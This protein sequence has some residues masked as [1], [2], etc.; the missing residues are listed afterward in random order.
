MKHCVPTQI[1][2]DRQASPTRSLATPNFDLDPHS[3]DSRNQYSVNNV[4]WS[5]SDSD[6]PGKR[7]KV[8][9]VTAWLQQQNMLAAPV[10]TPDVQVHGSW[11]ESNDRINQMEEQHRQERHAEFGFESN[12]DSQRNQQ[13]AI[14]SGAQWEPRHEHHPS[15]DYSGAHQGSAYVAHHQ[16]TERFSLVSWEEYQP[17]H[18]ARPSPYSAMHSVQHCP[19]EQS[20]LYTATWQGRDRGQLSN[21]LGSH[22]STLHP[23]RTS[24]GQ[25][26]RR[27]LSLT[28]TDPYPHLQEN[29]GQFLLTMSPAEQVRYEHHLRRQRVQMLHQ[30]QREQRYQQQLQYEMYRQDYQPH[31]EAAH[32]P[33]SYDYY[34]PQQQFQQHH[35]H[36][37]H[38]AS[39]GRARSRQEIERYSSMHR[40]SKVRSVNDLAWERHFFYQLQHHQ[41]EALAEQRRIES[42]RMKQEQQQQQQQQPQYRDSLL[43]PEQDPVLRTSSL[44]RITSS[45]LS[46]RTAQALGLSRSKSVSVASVRPQ[47]SAS[48][49]SP[50]E[51]GLM[52]SVVSDC[53]FLSA[54]RRLIKRQEAKAAASASARTSDTDSQRESDAPLPTLMVHSQESTS[55]LGRRKTLKDFAPSIRSLARRCSSRFSSRPNS[56]A[57]CSSDPI[58]Q[59]PEGKKATGNPNM[60]PGYIS[61]DSSDTSPRTHLT[62]S[63]SI[64]DFQQPETATSLGHA[65]KHNS[66]DS[67]T[68]SYGTGSERIP[69]HRKVTLFRS[70]TTTVPRAHSAAAHTAATDGST[71]SS[72]A[73]SLS[74]R[75]ISSLRLANGR[76]LDL[77]IFQSMPSAVLDVKSSSNHHVDAPA[78]VHM[79]RDSSPLSNIADDEDPQKLARRQVLTLLAMGRKDRVSAKTGQVLPQTPTPS[80]DSLLSSWTATTAGEQPLSPLALETRDDEDYEQPLQ[81]DAVGAMQVGGVDPCERIAFMLVPKSRYEFQ[82]LVAL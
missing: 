31:A 4:A 9:F 27:S 74:A 62:S 11:S 64:V 75:P 63:G 10:E 6:L 55:S 21:P 8:D 22:D 28:D 57:G 43:V 29:Q 36:Y 80:P 73:K 24:L 81:T 15:P 49:L 77:E 13:T 59:F 71:T 47:S 44:S 51:S 25:G 52:R 38:P 45:S 18:F 16:P 20:H 48:T 46:P 53:K 17:P 50:S 70:K 30:Q 58:V 12:P 2:R 76:G 79:D 37:R 66:L 72:R 7:A 40:S 61:P 65:S 69:I 78:I 60:R 42:L 26:H 19:S 82:P 5:L 54:G 33:N 3:S 41:E 68:L 34:G 39:L 1:Y 35:H 56:F 14:N 67:S 32:R 23:S